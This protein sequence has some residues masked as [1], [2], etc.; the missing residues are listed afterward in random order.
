MVEPNYAQRLGYDFVVEQVG[1]FS[2]I[3]NQPI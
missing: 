1:D 2:A 3:R